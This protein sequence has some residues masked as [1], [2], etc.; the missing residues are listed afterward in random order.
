MNTCSEAKIIEEDMARKL[1]GRD[2]CE[3][4]VATLQQSV[5]SLHF[6]SWEEKEA[7][8]DE[9]RKL[10]EKS[11]K[12]RKIMVGLGVIPPLVAMVGSRV[13]ARQ[14]L[15]VRALTELANGSFT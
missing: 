7:A 9:I 2:Y 11:L 3:G 5:K 13:V 4:W 1:E 12:R 8:A 10:A 15:A 6:G 14:S